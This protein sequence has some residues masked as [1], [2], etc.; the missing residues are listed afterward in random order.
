VLGIALLNLEIPLAEQIE[1]GHLVVERPGRSG[2]LS[3]G[4]SAPT[5]LLAQDGRR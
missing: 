1:R 3:F 5:M 2:S 4:A